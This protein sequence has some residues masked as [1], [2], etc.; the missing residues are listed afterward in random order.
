M[1]P[2]WHKCGCDGFL[3]REVAAPV[4]VCTVRPALQGD[5]RMS[6]LGCLKALPQFFTCAVSM[7]SPLNQDDWVHCTDQSNILVY[8]LAFA[9][10][11]VPWHRRMH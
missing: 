7:T 6:S 5:L 4:M 1:A 11:F 10:A 3:I 8:F 9:A 2:L